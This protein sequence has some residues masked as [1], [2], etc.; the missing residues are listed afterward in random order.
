MMNKTF[1]PSINGIYFKNFDMIEDSHGIK[2]I[3]GDLYAYF[4]ENQ[5]VCIGYFNPV[6]QTE[7][8]K[9]PQYF[10][11][12]EEDYHFLYE[13][14]GRYESIFNQ[15]A[16]PLAE[17]DCSV[18]FQELIA[19][20]EI[21]TYLYEFMNGIEPNGKFEEIGLVGLINGVD[22]KPIVKV[23]QIKDSNIRTNEQIMKFIEQ[24]IESI[25]LNLTYP[26]RIFKNY[27]DFTICQVDGKMLDVVKEV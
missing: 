22:K 1:Y 21:I 3:R 19:D 15:K 2:H 7:A 23:I 12:L 6:Y 27:S 16:I 8:G 14:E 10:L 5:D 20:L 17:Y 11:R 9:P 4:P 18:G 26:V 25:Q 13:T 24:H